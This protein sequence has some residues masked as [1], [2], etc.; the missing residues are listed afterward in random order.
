MTLR[1]N[2]I[3][4]SLSNF[5]MSIKILCIVTNENVWKLICGTLLVMWS[6]GQSYIKATLDIGTIY[7]AAVI[8]WKYIFFPDFVM[9]HHVKKTL[10][11]PFQLYRTISTYFLI[12]VKIL[13][14]DIF[15]FLVV[16]GT[17][18]SA[19]TVGLFLG[20]CMDRTSLYLFNNI[21]DLWVLCTEKKSGVIIDYFF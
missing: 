15:P 4:L 7:F 16:F 3:S 20:Q 2:T 9:F 6:H 17:I 1:Y 18:L 12:L 8:L 21:Q 5:S 13:K 10:I 11:L 14:H 19:A